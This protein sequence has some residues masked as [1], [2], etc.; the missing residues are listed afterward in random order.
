LIE[1]IAARR[2][3]RG[4]V[5]ASYYLETRTHRFFEKRSLTDGLTIVEISDVPNH[6]DVVLKARLLLPGLSER[7]GEFVARNSF[8]M[9]LSEE[10][11]LGAVKGERIV[12]ACYF[13]KDAP[14]SRGIRLK[15]ASLKPGLAQRKWLSEIEELGD[16]IVVLEIT[17]IAPATVGPN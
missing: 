14:D 16:L 3:G 2:E 1:L 5:A 9:G 6:P 12:K 7:G 13:P 11:L 10:E 4:Q 17:R 15:A 8:H